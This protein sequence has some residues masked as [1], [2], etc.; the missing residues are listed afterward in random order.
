MPLDP[1][2][3]QG[4]SG[5]RYALRRF[6]AASER[7]CRASELTAQQ[8][9][10]LLAIKAGDGTDMSIRHLADQLLL[11]HHAAVQMIDRLQTDG[12]AA[13][14]SSEKD[15]RVALLSL[16]EKGQALIERLAAEHLEELL[17]QAPLLRT[18]LDR[19]SPFDEETPDL[20]G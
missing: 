17:R 11:T 14:K 2:V 8:Y 12:L 9:Q 4:L 7:I 3:F 10:A 18:S 5:F 6:L 16:T 15:R 1:A 19:L 13:R 20:V